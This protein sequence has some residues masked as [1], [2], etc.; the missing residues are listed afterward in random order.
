M[1]RFTAILG[2]LVAATIWVLS[3]LGQPANN[4][5]A[6]NTYIFGDP[7]QKR[8][9]CGGYA[10]PGQ[11]NY[12]GQA[13]RGQ[14]VV[15]PVPQGDNWKRQ[16]PPGSPT[17]KQ[18]GGKPGDPLIYSTECCEFPPWDWVQAGDAG[19]NIVAYGINVAPCGVTDFGTSNSSQTGTNAYL[20]PNFLTG[21]DATT[22]NTLTGATPTAWIGNTGPYTNN[23]YA[24]GTN[25]SN[26]QIGVGLAPLVNGGMTDVAFI[27]TYTFCNAVQPFASFTHLQMTMNFTLPSLYVA[28]GDGLIDHQGTGFMYMTAVFCNINTSCPGN[29]A[30]G[31][32]VDG[33]GNCIYIIGRVA[34]NAYPSGTDASGVGYENLFGSG[35]RYWFDQS[36]NPMA[37]LEINNGSTQINSCNG[38]VTFAHALNPFPSPSVACWNIT[39][40]QFSTLIANFN[41]Q[42]TLP[43]GNHSLDTTA[44]NWSLAIVNNDWEAWT[45][46]GGA[47]QIYGSTTA[48]Q[49]SLF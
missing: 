44:S 22:L 8:T 3:A 33:K 15:R 1:L 19:G 32:C 43:Y 47:V 36:Y 12:A 2:T 10:C 30:G 41:A 14:K 9:N 38:S 46:G 45:H 35:D 17:P 5:G 24:L 39:A 34:Q 25:T 40:T 6:G 28:P 42:S 49:V 16:R 23:Y 31:S 20:Y 13:V 37:N 7:I 21:S 26:T 29:P 18:G 4:T 48:M 11:S 27:Q